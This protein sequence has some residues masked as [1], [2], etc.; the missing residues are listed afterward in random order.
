[1][2]QLAHMYVCIR[3]QYMLWTHCSRMHPLLKQYD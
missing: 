2:N 1:V 3:M